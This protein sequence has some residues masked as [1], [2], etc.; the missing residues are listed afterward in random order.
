MKKRFAVC[1]AALSLVLSF[2]V[3]LVNCGGGGGGGGSAAAPTTGSITGKVSNNATG[4]A[5]SGATVSDGVTTATTGADGTYTMSSLSPVSRKVLTI[6]ASNFAFTSK[7]AAVTAGNTS[8]VDVAL[9][10][11]AAS[12]TLASL[13]TAQTLTVANSTAQVNLSANGL[14]TAA[15]AAP[16]LPVTANITPIDPSSNPQLMPGDYT[17]SAGAMIESF[18]AMEV[19]FKDNAGA[20]LKLA[21][22]QTATIRIPV[23]AA[24]QGTAA[25]TMPAFYY[26]E[27]TG[28]WVEEGTLTL[29]GTAPNKYY[30][31][32]VTHFS[33]WNAD[34]VYNTTC[35][36][37]RVVNA[38]GT[39]VAGARVEAQGRDYTGTSETYTGSDGTFTIKV[40]ANVALTPGIIITASTSDALSNSEV[41]STGAAGSVCTA[42]TADLKLGAVIGGV[43]SGSAK[44]K[45][46]WGTEPYD[47][48]SHLTGPDATVAGT[49][50]HVY[51][52]DQGSIT[53][54]PYAELDV[55]D[56]SGLG[57]EIVTISRFTAGTYRYSIHH[58]GGSNTIYGSP[59]RVELSLNGATTI[60]TPP[61]T[62]S[63]SLSGYGDV[64]QVFELVVAANGTVTVNTLGTYVTGVGSSSVT[65]PGLNGGA[66]PV[67]SGWDW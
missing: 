57:P 26:N 61:S 2:A 19:N 33:Y 35:I 54:S 13:A 7:A 32:T 18:G 55:D 15:G 62:G 21:T 12:I 60:F 36:T 63:S 46:T 20:K 5:I 49:R 48:D 17:T 11:V 47:L 1:M 64:W 34:Q 67:L 58:Y 14:T 10:P 51:Y 37:G 16:S 45:L 66:K 41:V 4:A 50:F 40:K 52:S 31:G 56:T 65:K 38:S 23:P 44:I 27:T 53:A 59:A 42:L 24:N 6:S 43:G 9:Q 39:P 25:S 30:E 29:G 3:V 28:Q 8:R 22:G